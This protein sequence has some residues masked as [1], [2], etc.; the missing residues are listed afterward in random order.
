MTQKPVI[1]NRQPKELNLANYERS[2]WTKVLGD[3]EPDLLERADVGLA[4]TEFLFYKGRPF[5]PIGALKNAQVME[6]WLGIGNIATQPDLIFKMSHFEDQP[7]DFNLFEILLSSNQ[8]AAYG[9]WIFGDRLTVTGEYHAGHHVIMTEF[10][11]EVFHF[12]Y[13]PSAGQ[14]RCVDE[15]L[16]T[17]STGEVR[18]IAKDCY[19]L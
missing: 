18:A 4:I 12:Q 2:R 8:G 11:G 9:G 6:V 13:Y 16:M 1:F 19:R 10:R 17:L 3:L 7:T 14:Y 15:D 5:Y